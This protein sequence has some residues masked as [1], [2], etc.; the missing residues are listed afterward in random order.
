MTKKERKKY[1]LLP[2]KATESEIVFMRHG[3]FGSGGSIYI[4]D[5]RQNTLFASI[6]NDRSSNTTQVG[7]KLLKPQINQ[8]HPPRICFITPGWHACYP[9]PQFIV[10]D[11]GDRANSNMITNK[12]VRMT[13]MALKPNQL[14]VT[15]SRP[16]TN[17]ITERLHK[18]VN[19]MLRSFDLENENIHLKI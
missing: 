13:I 12:C 17:G 14:Q 9:Q 16:Q 3:L 15:T 11:N 4:K 18:V 6:H 10:F 8:Q 1:G 19:D 2:L 5:T 7:L